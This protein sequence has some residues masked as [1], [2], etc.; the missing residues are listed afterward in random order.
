MIGVGFGQSHETETEI[1]GHVVASFLVAEKTKRMVKDS[2]KGASPRGAF[3]A[4]ALKPS[5]T[6]YTVLRAKMQMFL[7][8]LPL[9]PGLSYGMLEEKNQSFF[10]VCSVWRCST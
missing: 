3:I 7:W 10:R 2:D 6:Y 4:L 1:F 5:Q 8:K 9:P